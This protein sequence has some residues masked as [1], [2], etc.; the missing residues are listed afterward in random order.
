MIVSDIISEAGTKVAW[1]R[2]SGSNKVVRKYRC[3]SGPR[4]GQMRASPAA[5]NAPYKF[6]KAVALK[7]TKAKLGSHGTFTAGRTKKY[8]PGSRIVRKL[9]KPAR[10]KSMR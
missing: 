4:K 7:K 5:C 1:K 6:K 9:N 8:N 2:T 3:T 10:R